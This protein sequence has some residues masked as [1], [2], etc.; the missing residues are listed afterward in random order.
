VYHGRFIVQ[1]LTVTATLLVSATAVLRFVGCSGDSCSPE[2]TSVRPILPFA[3]ELQA[4]IDTVLSDRGNEEFLGISAA[5]LVPGYEP[6][7]GV[8]GWSHEGVPM[9]RSLVFDAGSIA[10]TFEAVLVLRLVEQG[11]LD[12]DQ[13][14]STWL[15]PLHNIDGDVTIRQ[16]LNHTSGVRNVFDHPDFPWVG[17]GIDY[18]RAWTPSEV[19]DAF[20]LEPYGGPGEVQRYASTNYLLIT[21]IIEKAAGVAAPELVT[22]QLLEPQGLDHSFISVGE[23]LPASLTAAHP[24]ADMDGDGVLEDLSGIPRTWIATLTHPVLCTTPENLT[25]WTNALLHDRSLLTPGS[26]R[27]MLT[28]PE[29]IQRDPGG[30]R[31]GLGI[32]DY[33]DRLGMRVIGHTG[34]SPGYSAAALYLPDHGVS[35]A[36]MINT[37]E[38]PGD[39]AGALM[40]RTWSGLSD[41]LRRHL[42]SDS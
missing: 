33:S 1:R 38:G 18:G 31:Y 37:G 19:C 5:V 34:S 7:T 26:L 28:F 2:P 8:S 6:W 3:T 41:V 42:E 30:D 36:W 22:Q 40:S 14:V 16:L 12:L 29:D 39:L 13:P 15:P 23:M 10:K 21:A 35:M 24:W 25:R 17:R 27:A 9:A 4:A 20:V 11:V 32:I